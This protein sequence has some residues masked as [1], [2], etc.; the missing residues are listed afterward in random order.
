MISKENFVVTIGN[1]GTVVALHRNNEIINKIFL[2][3]LDEQIKSE[4]KKLFNKHSSSQIFIL[5]DSVDQSYKK[6]SYPP[7]S[8]RD[9]DNIIKRDIRNDPDKDALKSHILLNPKKLKSEKTWECLFISSHKSDVVNEWI[10]F[11]LDTKNHLAGIFM[12]PVESFHLFKKLISSIKPEENN[13]NSK[14]KNIAKSKGVY[15]VVVQNKVSGL[16]QIVF[17]KTG[18]IFTRVVNYNFEESDF[19]KKY[20]HDIY[21]TFEYL[22][23]IFPEILIHEF[24]VINILSKKTTSIIEESTNSEIKYHNLTPF[25]ASKKI[26]FKDIIP[27]NAN[28]CDLLIS[29]IFAKEK[30]ILKLTTPKIAFFNRVFL[31]LK[32]SHYINMALCGL[33]SLTIAYTLFSNSQNNKIVKDLNKKKELAL[34]EFKNIEFSTLNENNLT[35]NGKNIDIETIIDFGTIEANLQ[36]SEINLIKFYE[37]LRFLGKFKVILKNFNLRTD[38]SIKNPQNLSPNFQIIIDGKINN[39]SGD[40]DDLFKNFDLLVS[41]VKKAYDGNK[42]TYTELPR[43]INFNEK[44]YSFPINFIISKN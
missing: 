14:V 12:L 28:Y 43:N 5:L 26:G 32:I 30:K 27:E 38:N 35:E 22:K 36:S 13:P 15:C 4:L 18:I 7:L 39:K 25:E 19:L 21:G 10:D 8:R 16:R 17:T 41:E 33:I 9:L 11:L 42:I 44:Y 1:Y 2:E 37:K 23:R 20:E 31:S 24:E 34:Q 40:I 3:K 6:K 29:N